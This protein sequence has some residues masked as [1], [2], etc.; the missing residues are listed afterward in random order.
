[1]QGTKKLKDFLIDAKVPRYERDS[2]P[3]LVCQ[4]EVLW[5]IGYTSSELF[6][7]KPST[8]QYLHLRYV[9]DESSS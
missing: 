1:M 3:L 9:S 7:I 4:D 2:I 8:R 5:L 6:K